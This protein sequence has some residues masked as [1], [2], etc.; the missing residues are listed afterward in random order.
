LVAHDIFYRATL[1]P[2]ALEQFTLWAS[3]NSLSSIFHS[4]RCRQADH[5][6]ARYTTAA[7]RPM[8][9]RGKFA[10]LN[11]YFDRRSWRA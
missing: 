3:Q 8:D 7:V 1:L 10:I 11:K 2:R 9:A 5:S 4:P 6:L